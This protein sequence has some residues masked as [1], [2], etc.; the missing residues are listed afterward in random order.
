MPFWK[1]AAPNGS[2]FRN[3]MLTLA[4]IL[5]IIGMILLAQ[6]LATAKKHKRTRE[7]LKRK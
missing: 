7:Q 2:K 4:I 1:G 3:A 6:R 5:F